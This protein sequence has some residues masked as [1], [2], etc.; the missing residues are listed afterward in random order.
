MNPKTFKALQLDVKM[1]E[2]R[3]LV[4]IGKNIQSNLPS[5]IHVPQD[6]IIPFDNRKEIDKKRNTLKL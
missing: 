2:P 4:S 3:I 6:L 1:I 5:D